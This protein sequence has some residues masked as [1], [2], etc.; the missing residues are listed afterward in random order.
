M[1]LDS[2]PRSEGWNPFTN[3]DLG[4]QRHF[5]SL[6]MGQPRWFRKLIIKEKD[7]GCHEADCL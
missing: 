7:H 3:M 5:E 6:R 2:D 4:T 1:E